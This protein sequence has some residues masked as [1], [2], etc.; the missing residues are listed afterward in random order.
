MAKRAGALFDPNEAATI[1][2]RVLEE[3][4]AVERMR[5]PSAKSNA[6]TNDNPLAIWLNYLL[7]HLSLTHPGRERRQTI[8]PDP[9]SLS[10]L[11]LERLAADL[12]IAKVDQSTNPLQGVI[13]RVALSF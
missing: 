11:A 3:I 5:R 2:L 9:F 1:K 6:V 8:E 13:F 7:H 4:L 12:T 10:L